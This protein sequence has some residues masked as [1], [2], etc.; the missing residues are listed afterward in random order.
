MS[1]K[2][3]TVGIDIDNTLIDY[4][5]VF[6]QV[7]R[8]LD[9]LPELSDTS[10][11]ATKGFL[12]DAKEFERWTELQGI[13]YG[14]ML[15]KAALYSG[16]LEC[17]R[18]LLAAGVRV[19]IISHKTRYP[20][21]GPKVDLHQAALSF[22]NDQQLIGDEPNQVPFSQVHFLEEKQ[23]KVA[24]IAEAKC[25]VFIDD[26]LEIFALDGF[27]SRTQALWFA[28][29]LFDAKTG[30]ITHQSTHI[31]SQLTD[32]ASRGIQMQLKANWE[33]IQ[34]WL[35]VYAEN[36]GTGNIDSAKEKHAELRQ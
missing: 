8:D 2:S 5:G 27:P 29:E 16:A 3:F 13:V 36:L 34:R 7:G 19:E 14:R 4:T 35:Q 11:A 30:R 22:L 26:L 33:E 20:Y 15:H 10:K 23:T 32:L 28:P 12:H 25:D 31:V 21:L 6:Y 1:Q 17:V 24:R 9:W 18:G